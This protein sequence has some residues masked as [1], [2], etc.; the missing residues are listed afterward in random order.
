MKSCDQPDK[1]NPRYRCASVPMEGYDQCIKCHQ[2]YVQAL[3]E[4]LRVATEALEKIK[5]EK[6]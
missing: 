1:E 3:E 6:A 4:K 2:E 5:G